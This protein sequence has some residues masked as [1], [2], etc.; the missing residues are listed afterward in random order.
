MILYNYQEFQGR[1]QALSRQYLLITAGL[2]LIKSIE[3]WREM[4]G[5]KLGIRQMEC[6]PDKCK[7]VYI[8]KTSLNIQINLS[9]EA[10]ATQKLGNT[11]SKQIKLVDSTTTASL[12]KRFSESLCTVL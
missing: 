11:T 5:V 2:F 10:T 3:V 1:K 7:L 6:N 4:T 8:G 9:L 12:K